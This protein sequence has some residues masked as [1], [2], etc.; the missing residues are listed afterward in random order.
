ME[1]AERIWILLTGVVTW[2]DQETGVTER[3]RV[4]WGTR[5]A[6]AG[7]HSYNWWWVIRYGKRPCGCTVNPLTRRRVLTDMD[8]DQHGF[9]SITARRRR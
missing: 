6:L 4:D 8:C 1:M 9:S 5:W 3:E 7:V 2:R